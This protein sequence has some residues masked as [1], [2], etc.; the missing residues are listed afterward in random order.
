MLRVLESWCRCGRVERPADTLGTSDAESAVKTADLTLSP[1]GHKTLEP[2]ALPYT[3]SDM[4]G[5]ASSAAQGAS[6]ESSQGSCGRPSVS[7]IRARAEETASDISGASVLAELFPDHGTPG[8]DHQGAPAGRSATDAVGSPQ[9]APG[10]R[11]DAAGRQATHT[12][13]MHDRTG[14]VQA[15]PSVPGGGKLFSPDIEQ[16]GM[17]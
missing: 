3:P 13:N 12:H 17:Q 14:S 5:S 6:C 8:P 11:S 1:P 15:G 4:S 10:A 7:T 16:Q 9:A 2:A